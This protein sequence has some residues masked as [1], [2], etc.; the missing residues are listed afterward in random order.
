MSEWPNPECDGLTAV[1]AVGV[2]VG[3]G[4]G[5]LGGDTIF[6]GNQKNQLTTHAEHGRYCLGEKFVRLVVF[7]RV[8]WGG[9]PSIVVWDFFDL[10]GH[11]CLSHPWFLIYCWPDS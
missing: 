8:D 1:G 7:V 11:N 9:F 3:D 2:Y 5:E 10:S 4:D 6:V